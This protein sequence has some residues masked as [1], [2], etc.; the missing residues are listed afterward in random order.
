MADVHDSK[1]R[2]RNMAAIRGVNTQPELRLRRALHKRG[3]R[4][5]LH[6][7]GLPGRPDLVLPKYHAAI[8]VH[9]CFFHGHECAT[10]RWPATNA[11]FW[12]NKIEQNRERDE[13]Q[14]SLLVANGWRVL[15]VWECVLRRAAGDK[16]DAVVA[17]VAR[18]LR[19]KRLRFEVGGA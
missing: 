18:W 13:K 19:G 3:F 10:F 7:A 6:R 17:R 5:R 16:S 15:V 11:N 14:I 4:Y 12:R 1:T 8:F 9:G 2:S